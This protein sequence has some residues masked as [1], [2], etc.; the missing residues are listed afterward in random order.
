MD[1]IQSNLGIGQTTI[2]NLHLKPTD[3]TGILQFYRTSFDFKVKETHFL[4]CTNYQSFFP[5]DAI[6][7]EDIVVS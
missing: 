3:L 4:F 2:F 5:N 6:L 1:P 7:Q